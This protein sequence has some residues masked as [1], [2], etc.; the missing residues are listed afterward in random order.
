MPGSV[1]LRLVGGPTALLEYGG[2]RL[3]TD[4]TLDP[5]G[6]HRQP[7]TSIVL[8]KL[9]GPAVELDELLPIDA[10][11]LSHDHHADN[12][13]RSG[14][15][16][17][18]LAGRVLCT[19]AGAERL[20]GGVTAMVPGDRVELD[21]P[22]GGQLSITAVPAE[23][24][25][26]D[27]AS[28]NGPVI[29][30]VL[31]GEGLP[32]TYVSGDN[33]SVRVVRAIAEEY[34]PIELAVLFVGGAQVPAAW[35]DAFLTLTAETAMQAARELGDAAIVP[36]HQDGWEH[37]TSNAADVRSAFAAAGLGGRLRPVSPG[38]EL[39]LA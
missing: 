18:A 13:D 36:I 33:A 30:F 6:E 37:F 3:L 16:M 28:R 7:G 17:L 32:T 8:R 39:T 12:L 2:L 15:A 35:G 27:V 5:P 1:K 22:D 24:G 26:P 34:G 23:D 9:S 31:S 38:E 19:D 14:R 21:R 29:G 4:P 20:G 25:P 10:V 11:L